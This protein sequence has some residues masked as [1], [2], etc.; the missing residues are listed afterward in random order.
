[1]DRKELRESE[2][3]KNDFL[4]IESRRINEENNQL[5]SSKSG[6]LGRRDIDSGRIQIILID[7]GTGFANK[8]TNSGIAAL[9]SVVPAI[10]SNNGFN[11]IDAKP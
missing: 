1:M 4:F 7:G 8:I 3:L 2:R 5:N 9:G 11:T 6:N 10:I